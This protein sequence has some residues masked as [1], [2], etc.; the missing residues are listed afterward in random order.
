[1]NSTRT[2]EGYSNTFNP[3]PMIEIIPE[4]VAPHTL[5]ASYRREETGVNLLY[6]FTYDFREDGLPVREMHPAYRGQK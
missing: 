3:Y 4:V 5:P 2:F 6:N 1:M